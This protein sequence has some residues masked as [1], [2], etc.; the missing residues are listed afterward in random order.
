MIRIV[1]IES[2][3]VPDPEQLRKLFE[4]ENLVVDHYFET[5][6]TY[7]V[8]DNP[9]QQV[10]GK[11]DSEFLSY[12]TALRR[13]EEQFGKQAVRQALNDFLWRTLTGKPIIAR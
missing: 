6:I 1:K 10:S 4:G 5:V 2:G 12:D 7:S 13:L 9:P 11:G 3:Y 8:G